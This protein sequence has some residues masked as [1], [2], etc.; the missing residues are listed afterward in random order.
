MSGL[1]PDVGCLT[2][3]FNCS[4]FL[5][6]GEGLKLR[7]A[8]NEEMGSANIGELVLAMLTLL[9]ERGRG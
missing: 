7:L 6:F 1:P 5:I 9:I 2:I 8:T 4:A 3:C